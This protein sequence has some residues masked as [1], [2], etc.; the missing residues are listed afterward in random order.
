MHKQ[1]RN[2]NEE[3]RDAVTESAIRFTLLVLHLDWKMMIF[4]KDFRRK[5]KANCNLHISEI[6]VNAFHWLHSAHLS[7]AL[8]RSG[9][10]S[11]RSWNS[12]KLKTR[13]SHRDVFDQFD[14]P[15]DWKFPGFKWNRIHFHRKRK[16]VFEVGR[17]VSNNYRNHFISRFVSSSSA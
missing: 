15:T 14:H 12:L 4:R 2:T 5:T 9:R 13:K 10:I 7:T 1:K 17:H 3:R 6:E 16:N 11:Y 8:L